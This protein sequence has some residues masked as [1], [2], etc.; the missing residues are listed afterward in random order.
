MFVCLFVMCMFF[1]R[2]TI[3]VKDS[4]KVITWI[5]KMYRRYELLSTIWAGSHCV[6]GILV[7]FTEQVAKITLPFILT[8]FTEQ[9]A[10]ITLPL[11]SNLFY[12][13]G[14]KDHITLHSNLSS[15]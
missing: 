10:K 5:F 6:Y 8:C 4:L 11:H 9:V 12:R 2:N 7:Y 15:L 14:S 3:I 1:L 13:A